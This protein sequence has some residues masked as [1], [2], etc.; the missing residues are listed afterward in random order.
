VTKAAEVHYGRVEERAVQLAEALK[1]HD[2][3]DTERFDAVTKAL[4]KIDKN[5]ESLIASRS[6]TRGV[7]RAAVVAGSVVSGTVAVVFEI[8][9]WWKTA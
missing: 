4:E 1:A 8:L 9:K 7:W 5:V 2:R 3:L 6:F